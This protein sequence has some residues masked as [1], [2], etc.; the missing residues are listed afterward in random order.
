MALLTPRFSY[1]GDEPNFSGLFRLIEG[2]D[3]YAAET[4]RHGDKNTNHK[5][6]A[7]VFSPKFDVKETET[8][9]VLQG[10]LPG[11]DKKDIN[12]EFTDPQTVRIHGKVERSEDKEIEEPN[13]KDGKQ[14]VKYWISERSV[15]DFSRSFSFPEKVD[16][17][18]ITATMREG[19]L[20]L[21]VPKAKKVDVRKKITVA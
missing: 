16:H 12:I 19:V 3:K 20:Y 21:A 11:V 7:S 5:A 8:T 6:I 9:Y 2:F 18:G 17:D 1:A 15:G 14:K 4:N 10:E 13:D